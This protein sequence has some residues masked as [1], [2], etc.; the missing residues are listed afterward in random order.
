[1]SRKKQ[2]QRKQQLRSKGQATRLDHPTANSLPVLESRDDESLVAQ[3]S[4]AQGELMP[5]T[6]DPYLLE[7]A[8]SQWQFGDW[9]SLASLIDL[10]LEHHPD[11]AKLALLAASGLIQKSD[12]AAG[13]QQVR[14]AREWGCPEKLI[15]QI[16]ISGVHNSLAQ[17][18]CEAAQ[19]DKANQHLLKAIDTVFPH[20][21]QKLLVKARS[22]SIKLLEKKTEH[23]LRLPKQEKTSIYTSAPHKRLFIDCGGYDGCS[24]IKFLLKN[25]DFDCIS[26]EPNEVLWEFYENIPT[27]L[28]KKAVSDFDGDVTFIID[29]VDADGSSIIKE[30]KID[31]HGTVDNADCPERKVPCVDLSN[32]ILD[33]SKEYSEII[34]KLDVEGAEYLVLK[35]MIRD[36]TIDLVSKIYAEFHWQK[37]NLDKNE[38]DIIYDQISSKIKVYDWDAQD[39]AVYKRN[40]NLRSLRKYLI[41]VINERI[42]VK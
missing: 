3:Q 22:N 37:M 4:S 28:I 9:D 34:L 36:K 24:S 13:R 31:F 38:H 25:P 29:P 21:D 10:K 32:F 11:R 7:R 18:N 40:G 39:F 17:A 1:M 20:H 14:L 42:D 15:K 19:L 12:M 2:A 41:E 35:K 26:F 8:R 30:K 23:N 33:K 16:L 6:Y 27:L 5:M